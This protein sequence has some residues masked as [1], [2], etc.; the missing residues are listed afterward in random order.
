MIVS[1]TDRGLKRDPPI[2]ISS[3]VFIRAWTFAALFDK[4]S[5]II[6]SWWRSA[7]LILRKRSVSFNGQITP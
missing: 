4:F 3:K 7:M 5:G 2:H 1:L 6:R